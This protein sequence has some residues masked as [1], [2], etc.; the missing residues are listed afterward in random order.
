MNSMYVEE[1]LEHYRN[2]KNFGTINDAQIRY[3]ESNPLCGDEYEFYLKLNDGVIADV[4]FSGDGCAI[5]KA[6]ASMLSENIKEKSLEE[7]KKMKLD[8]VLKLLN[9]E[10]SAARIQCALL[11]LIAV[12]KGIQNFNEV[13]K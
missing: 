5:S 6:S 12:Q 2:P 13:N 11:P 8:D 4:K 3:K 10:V 1:I 9:I 7:I